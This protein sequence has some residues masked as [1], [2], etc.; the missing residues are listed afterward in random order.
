MKILLNG[1]STEKLQEQDQIIIYFT[2]AIEELCS[3]K[4]LFW[5]SLGKKI[6]DFKIIDKSV[7]QQVQLISMV[8]EVE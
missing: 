8:E 1:T 2:K 6:P 5:L 3:L 7:K 4:Y